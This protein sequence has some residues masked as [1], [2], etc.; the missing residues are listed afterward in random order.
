MNNPYAFPSNFSKSKGGALGASSSGSASDYYD[1]NPY[2]VPMMLNETK[3]YTDFMMEGG[4]IDWAKYLGYVRKGIEIAPKII[5]DAPQIFEGAKSAIQAVRDI[6]EHGD[7]TK[8]SKQAPKIYKGA[9]TTID[10]IKELRNVLKSSGDKVEEKQ[11]KQV[12][13]VK[14]GV[15]SKGKKRVLKRK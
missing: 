12:K 14:R 10:T 2:R 7:L 3:H 8:A 6:R 15:K 9:K 11:V 1:S 4:Q 13:Q 5:Q